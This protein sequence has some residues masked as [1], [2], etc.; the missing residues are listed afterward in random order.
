MLEIYCVDNDSLQK[1]NEA[2]A[3]EIKKLVSELGVSHRK[4]LDAESEIQELKKTIAIRKAEASQENSTLHRGI[5]DLEAEVENLQMRNKLLLQESQ[6]ANNNISELRALS[7]QLRAQLAERADVPKSSVA[8]ITD[9]S[10][11]VCDAFFTVY[12]KCI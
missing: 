3:E 11:T 2:L 4:L 5:K 12:S 6:S 10:G 8:T 9:I 7:N 1:S